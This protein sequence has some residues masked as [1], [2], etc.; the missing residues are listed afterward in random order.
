MPVTYK[1]QRIASG[2]YRYKGYDIYLNDPHY[3]KDWNLC[4]ATTDIVLVYGFETM[5]EAIGFIDENGLVPIEPSD[6]QV[7]CYP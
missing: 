1:K 3:D 4:I 6:L 5:R 2:V 7:G